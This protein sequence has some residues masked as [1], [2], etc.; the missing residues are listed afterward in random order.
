[1]K[2]L[3]GLIIQGSAQAE[4]VE[5]L[6]ALHHSPG[7]VDILFQKEFT[8]HE[9]NIIAAAYVDPYKNEQKNFTQMVYDIKHTDP[10]C[11]QQFAHYLETQVWVNERQLIQ[12]NGTVPLIY[13]LGLQDGFINSVYYKKV[14]LEAGLSKSQINLLDQVRHVPHLDNPALCAKLIVE[15][16]NS[17]LI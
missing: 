10:N 2:M 15:F 16:I 6:F 3:D 8:Q 14:L 12:N 9:C 1:L 7:P 17:I 4:S 11:R 5:K 13:I